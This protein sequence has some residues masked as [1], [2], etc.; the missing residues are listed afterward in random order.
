MLVLS[1][2][3]LIRQRMRRY[4]S[5][6]KKGSEAGATLRDSAADLWRKGVALAWRVPADG[7]EPP[8]GEMRPRRFGVALLA[9]PA[10][11][12][13]HQSGEVFH[14]LMISSQCRS[15]LSCPPAFAT[16]MTGVFVNLCLPS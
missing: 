1:G 9:A 11:R 8:M 15:D 7:A 2:Q 14:C 5:L 12:K 16:C 4:V 6:M 13:R 3:R 10:R